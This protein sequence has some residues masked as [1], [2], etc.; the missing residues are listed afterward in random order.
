MRVLTQLVLEAEHLAAD[1]QV[2]L[3]EA[4]EQALPARRVDAGGKVDV[5]VH[6][7]VVGGDE[8]HVDLR[9][10]R[11]GE[12][13]VL[14]GRVEADVEVAER[15]LGDRAR[16]AGAEELQQ[17][18]H[19]RREADRLASRL[20]AT[21]EDQ[22][23]PGAGLLGPGSGQRGADVE[24][25]P[26]DLDPAVEVALRRRVLPA[27]L[28]G[29]LL[30]HQ[31]PVIDLDRPVG[32]DLTLQ[33]EVAARGGLDLQLGD[34]EPGKVDPEVE[35]LLDQPGQVHDLAVAQLTVD[36]EAPIAGRLHL[37]LDRVLRV[38][39]RQDAAED[40]ARVSALPVEGRQDQPGDVEVP[41]RQVGC[42]R[43]PTRR[44]RT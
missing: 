4:A 33:A 27:E 35:G 5:G 39:E 11:T 30:Q 29:D 12:R 24:R 3:Q 17:R 10:R 26:A 19:R 15:D 1:G 14:G 21:L 44:S 37:E 2:A 23:R 43:P 20:A 16:Q 25:R 36:A 7:L 13:E 31:R 9:V 38:P 40:G 8:G 6:P 41:D 34:L 32:L 28:E 18:L 42:R 22:P